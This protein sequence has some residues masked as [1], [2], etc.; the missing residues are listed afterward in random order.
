MEIPEPLRELVDDWDAARAAGDAVRLASF[1]ADDATI[2]LPTGQALRGRDAIAAHY[3]KLPAVKER[4]KPRIGTR[5][6]FFFPPVVHATAT[7]SGRHGEKHS[8]VDILVQQPDGGFL[9]SF[10]SWTLR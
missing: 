4:D 3:S 10:S 8:F 6:F 7:A 1:Y 5:K 2:L 9:F